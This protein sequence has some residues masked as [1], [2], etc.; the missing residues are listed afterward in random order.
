MK[1]FNCGK[2]MKKVR[3]GHGVILDMCPSCHSMWFDRG[4]FSI[5]FDLVKAKARQVSNNL[6]GLLAFEK[7]IEAATVSEIPDDPGV[8]KA[9]GLGKLIQ[10]SHTDT[11][12]ALLKCTNCRGIGMKKESEAVIRKY[13]ERSKFQIFC[14][15]LRKLFGLKNK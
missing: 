5:Y 11:H 1:C 2:Q 12:A 14:D 10:I 8:C 13:T 4:E 3:D 6:D 15:R 9:C 7:K